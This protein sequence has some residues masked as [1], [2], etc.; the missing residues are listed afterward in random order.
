MEVVMR[1]PLLINSLRSALLAAGAALMAVASAAAAPPGTAAPGTAGVITA[2]VAIF[3]A[4]A[5]ATYA[6]A[7][8]GLR[9]HSTGAMLVTGLPAAPGMIDAWLY[10]SMLV[11]PGVAPP[12]VIAVTLKRLFPAAA[13][14]L[15]HLMLPLTATGADPCWGS[16][17]NAVYKVPVPLPIATGNGLYQI[18]VPKAVSAVATGVDP[19]TVP[20]VFPA[21]EGASLVLVGTGTKTVALYDYFAGT[22]FSA[23]LAYPLPLPSP[24]TG[25]PVLM[26]AFGAD[27]Q[28]GSG[29]APAPPSV[30]LETVT[31]NGFV[32]S[33]SPPG[34]D[35]DSDWNGSSTFP[36]P[37][38]WDDVG[39][40][41]TKAAPAGTGVLGVVI[42]QPGPAPNDCLIAVGNVVSY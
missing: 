30:H 26:D 8:V 2:P 18:T 21:A 23:G 25:G 7:G 38:L 24:T 6:T 5:A 33:G 36:L 11:K 17:G 41:I 34:S 39:H 16:G 35:T 28:I 42:G 1:H 14:N 40:D 32:V 29:R 22:E 31:V 27:G 13:P 19:F 9:N 10:V 15:V 37:Q 3:K 20:V 4:Y 12:P